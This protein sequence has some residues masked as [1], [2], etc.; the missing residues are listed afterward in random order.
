MFTPCLQKDAVC[1]V[2]YGEFKFEP[3]INNVSRALVTKGSGV[4]ELVDNS[5]GAAKREKVRR[6]AEEREKGECTFRPDVRKSR[7]GNLQAA[8]KVQAEAS[9][10]VAAS[11]SVR[12]NLSEVADLTM[13]VSRYNEYKEGVRR[14]KIKEREM[15]E[16]KECTFKPVTN[17]T[18]RRKSGTDAQNSPGEENEGGGEST[19][20]DVSYSKQHLQKKQG[21]SQPVVVRGLGRYLELKNMANKKSALQ[22]KREEDAFK[23]KRGGTGYRYPDGTTQV[24]EFRLTQVSGEVREKVKRERE[25]ALRRACTFKPDT[26]ERRNRRVIEGLLEEESSGGG[27]EEYSY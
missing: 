16:L 27:T 25:E 11:Q 15:E 4:Q 10:S 14:E 3:S 17:R 7:E 20:L 1:A 13:Q 23:V 12:I 5:R 21:G 2:M 26:V 22:K 24:K 8:A 6:E 18:R 19:P 9:E